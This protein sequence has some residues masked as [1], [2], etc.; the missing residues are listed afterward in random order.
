MDY[1]LRF[2]KSGMV[3][4][5]V[6]ANIGL[7]TVTTGLRLGTAGKVYAFEPGSDIFQVLTRNISLNALNKIVETYP[8]ALGDKVDRKYLLSDTNGGDADRYL[9]ASDPQDYSGGEEVQVTTLDKWAKERGVDKVNFVKLDC[10]GSELFVLQGGEKLL[11][12]TS[13]AMICCEV[14]QDALARQN[15]SAAQL[16]DYLEGLGFVLS[17]FEPYTRQLTGHRPPQ[18][19]NGNFFAVKS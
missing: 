3:V 1:A 16:Y 2:I 8:I 6:G 5:D 7:W 14:N 4:V 18:T 15:C 19:Y 17:Y 13:E 12:E 10:E 9:M 11:S